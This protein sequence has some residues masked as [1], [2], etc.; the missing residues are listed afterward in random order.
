VTRRIATAL[1]LVGFELFAAGIDGSASADQLAQA[2]VM[3][4]GEIMGVDKDGGQ[5]T[6]DH[7]PLLNLNMPAAV[8]VFQVRD[9]SVLDQLEVGDSVLFVAE[10]I[11]GRLTVIRIEIGPGEGHGEH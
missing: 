2:S 8:R 4:A 10:N 1:V 6:I 3:A 7:G 5:L 9:R 11:A